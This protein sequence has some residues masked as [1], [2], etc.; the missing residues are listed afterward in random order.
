VTWQRVCSGI[1]MASSS[2]VTAGYLA[3]LIFCRRLAGSAATPALLPRGARLPRVAGA[4]YLGLQ[5]PLTWGCR[6]R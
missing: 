2:A 4:A 1:E 3:R 5:A 6:R